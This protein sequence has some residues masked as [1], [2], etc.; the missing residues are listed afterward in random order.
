M[1]TRKLTTMAMLAALSVALV[2]LVHF[3]IFPAAPFLEYDPADIPILICGFAFG[4]LPGLAVTLLAAVVQGT[5][6]SAASGIYGI[7]MHFIATGTYVA[8]SSG[9][10]ARHKTRKAAAIALATGTLCTVFAMA[11]ANLL[12]TPLYGVPLEAVKEMMLP[13]I[14]PFN[15]IKMGVNGLVTFLVYKSISKLLHRL[16]VK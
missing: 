5:T 9:I 1:K 14:L 8:V 12:I 6:V 16:D 15:L 3:P 4:P 11:L 10:Y 7:I 2:A 13:V